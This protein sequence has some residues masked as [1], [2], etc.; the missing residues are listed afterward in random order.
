V[1][2]LS[3]RSAPDAPQSAD[4]SRAAEARRRQD[5]EGVETGGDDGTDEIE[6]A[7]SRPVTTDSI[8]FGRVCQQT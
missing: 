1:Q 4:C 7:S 5:A 2:V 6:P 8:E 3:T